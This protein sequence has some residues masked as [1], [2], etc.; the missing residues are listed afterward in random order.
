CIE[1]ALMPLT[2]TIPMPL[3]RSSPTTIQ[4]ALLPKHLR[5][6]VLTAV[7]HSETSSQR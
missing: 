1:D 4:Q 6:E 3:T 2:G 5:A 7:R